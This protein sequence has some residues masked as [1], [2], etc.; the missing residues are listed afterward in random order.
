MLKK[1]KILFGIALTLMFAM[2]F[3]LVTTPLTFAHSPP[4]EIP[5]FA[6]ISNP[7]PVGVGQV[8]LIVV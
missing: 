3:S 6:Y 8:L 7:N 2:T 1:N 5:T 4:W